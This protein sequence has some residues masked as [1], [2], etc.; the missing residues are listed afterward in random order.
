MKNLSM[1]QALSIWSELE[2]AR[3]G[4]HGFGSDTAEIYLYR[5]NGGRHLHMDSDDIEASN[6]SLYNLLD[7][8]SKERDVRIEVDGRALGEW[9]KTTGNRHRVHVRVVPAAEAAASNPSSFD[10]SAGRG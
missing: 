7:H 5:L 4:A 9:V 6:T 10:D 2:D 3:H 8:F 1:A